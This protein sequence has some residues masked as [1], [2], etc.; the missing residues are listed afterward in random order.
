M[1]ATEVS[2]PA[3]Q[4][5]SRPDPAW[6]TSRSSGN[7]TSARPPSPQKSDGCGFLAQRPTWR[8]LGRQIAHRGVIAAQRRTRIYGETAR[9]AIARPQRFEPCFVDAACRVEQNERDRARILAPGIERFRPSEAASEQDPSIAERKY[10][11]DV[12][13]DEVA[14]EAERDVAQE[15][16]VDRAAA[17]EAEYTEPEA[18][19]L[20]PADQQSAFG[21]EC[22]RADSVRERAAG[23]LE[24]LSTLLYP[25]KALPSPRFELSTEPLRASRSCARSSSERRGP[26]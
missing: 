16:F 4:A 24:S 17:V 8:W 9:G 7:T 22:E 15:G 13:D 3:E 25:I 21:V 6:K 2:P 10:L 18:G 5:A 1:G 23:A 14:L 20:A 26:R 12:P 11:R 19:C